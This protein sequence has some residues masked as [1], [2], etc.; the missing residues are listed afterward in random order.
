MQLKDDKT[1]REI[2][3]YCRDNGIKDINTFV[4]KIIRKGFTV[5]KFGERPD[6]L[7]PV[8]SPILQKKEDSILTEE[9][10]KN[11]EQSEKDNTQEIRPKKTTRVLK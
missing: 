7:S 6:I 5:E 2:K 4:L 1:I 10:K 11:S 9:P 3:D 8:V